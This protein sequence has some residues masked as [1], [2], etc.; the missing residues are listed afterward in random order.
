[1]VVKGGGQGSGARIERSENAN[2]DILIFPVR[3]QRRLG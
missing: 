2:N 3:S 1:M